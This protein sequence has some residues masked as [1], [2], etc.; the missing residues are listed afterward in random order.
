MKHHL[1]EQELIEY[2]FK[3][4]SDFRMEE[5]AEHLAGC[6]EC[7]K[8]LEQLSQKFAALDLLRDEVKVSE[9]LISQVIEQARQP[10]SAKVVPFVS[11]YP[12]IGAVAAMLVVGFVLLIGS[13][14][15]EKPTQREFARGPKSAQEP[16]P[17]TEKP[18]GV[19]EQSR[20]RFDSE[21]G[22]EEI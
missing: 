10:A 20:N 17:A 7:R 21:D 12:W 5:I 18:E 6:A 11:K 1:T 19:S 14:T 4:A 8:R 3:L 9:D 15:E 13:L 16:G 2:Q 22:G